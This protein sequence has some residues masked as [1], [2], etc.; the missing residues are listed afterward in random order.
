MGSI[1]V[2]F[3]AS[4]LSATGGA[5]SGA[6]C[7]LSHLLHKFR[8]SL[9]RNNSH[10]PPRGFHAARPRRWPGALGVSSASPACTVRRPLRV[11]AL[12]SA[13][14]AAAAR[15]GATPALRRLAKITWSL[16]F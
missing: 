1:V 3:P 9:L 5:F 2:R 7:V 6:S 11:P 4:M 8:V 16:V 10:G 15:P 14:L 12:L 13:A